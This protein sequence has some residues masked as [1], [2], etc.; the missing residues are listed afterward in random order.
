MEFI[1]DVYLIILTLDYDTSKNK[2]SSSKAGI[3]E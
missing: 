3:Y 1:D 2:G